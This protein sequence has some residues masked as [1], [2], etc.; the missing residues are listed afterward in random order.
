MFNGI[1]SHNFRRTICPCCRVKC[2]KSQ[3]HPIYIG[4]NREMDELRVEMEASKST[5]IYQDLIIKFLIDQ[6]YNSKPTHKT[7]LIECQNRKRAIKHIPKKRKV[8]ATKDNFRKPM[9]KRVMKT[10]HQK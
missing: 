10:C 8:S 4:S 1:F 2:K 7:K 3:L 9:V 5:I 6:Q